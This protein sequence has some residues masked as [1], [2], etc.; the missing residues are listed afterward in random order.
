MM[1]LIRAAMK[2]NKSGMG[3]M[4]TAEEGDEINSKRKDATIIGIDIRKANSAASSRRVP[5]NKDAAIVEP[6]RL[7]P[8]MTAMPCAMPAIMPFL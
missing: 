1:P 7:I 6:L 4:E 2:P 5:E 8:G 3:S